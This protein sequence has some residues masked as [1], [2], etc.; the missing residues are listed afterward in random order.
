MAHS[1]VEELRQANS[2]LR[3]EYMDLLSRA[4]LILRAAEAARNAF[5]LEIDFRFQEPERAAL[6]QLNEALDGFHVSEAQI[7]AKLLSLASQ[8]RH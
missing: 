8:D 4:R 5:Q 1:A 3:R 2:V 7:D 6:Q